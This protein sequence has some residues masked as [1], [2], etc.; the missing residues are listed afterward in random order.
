MIRTTYA[1]TT[2]PQAAPHRPPPPARPAHSERLAVA[3]RALVIAA[4]KYSPPTKTQRPTTLSTLGLK[5]TPRQARSNKQTSSPHARISSASQERGRTTASAGG[6]DSRDQRGRTTGSAG[7]LDSRVERPD[8][9]AGSD[10]RDGRLG[11]TA[12]LDGR[13]G[14]PRG[15]QRGRT[16]VSAGGS[17][18]RDQRG[19]TTGSAGGLDSRVERPDRTAGSDG[20]DGRLGR[21][22]GLDGRVG[23]PRGA[24]DGLDDLG[25]GVPLEG[26]ASMATRPG[27]EAPGN[28]EDF[29]KKQRTEIEAF[30]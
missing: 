21:T 5:T 28:T 2:R 19:R 22:A 17:D 25:Q 15:A 26:S 23:P 8:R 7:G 13:V 9:T 30:Y 20:R 1:D 18:S 11:R 12:G 24:Q 16:T 4:V 27:A 10:G 6:S 29:A 14:P 3:P